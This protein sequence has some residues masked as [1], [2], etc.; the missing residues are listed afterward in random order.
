MSSERLPNTLRMLSANMKTPA[1]NITPSTTEIVVRRKRT[2]L[3]AMFFRVR[4]KSM[5]ADSRL[6]GGQ[7]LKP[8]FGQSPRLRTVSKMLSK[9]GS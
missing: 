1:V 5:M 8:Q 2:F 3:S 9:V 6:T 7:G 4:R